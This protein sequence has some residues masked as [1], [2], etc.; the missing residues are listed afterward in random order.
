MCSCYRNSTKWKTRISYKHT[1]EIQRLLWCTA[2]TRS[3]FVQET[4]SVFPKWPNPHAIYFP[5][6]SN[7]RKWSACTTQKDE[8]TSCL[9]ACYTCQLQN[10]TECKWEDLHTFETTSKQT[11][12]NSLTHLV[13]S[14]CTHEIVPFLLVQWRIVSIS[15]LILNH[16]LTPRRCSKIHN[17]TIYNP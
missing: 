3:K 17:A 1:R 9:Y 14:S 10:C 6:M 13:Y 11:A 4:W 7:S 12:F 5:T 2:Q 16:I 15:K 8:V